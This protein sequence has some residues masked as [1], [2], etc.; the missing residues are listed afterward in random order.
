V[1]QKVNPYGLRLGIINDWRTRWYTEKD[2]AAYL[3][4]DIAIRR[5]IIAQLSHAGLSKIDI[6]RTEKQVKI[7]IHAGRPGIVI[8][9]KGAEVDKL[10]NHL[11]KLTGKRIKIDI[12]EVR[13]PETSAPLIAQNIAQQLEG[14][15]SFRRAMKKAV[16]QAIQGGAK[17]V[18]I[19]SAGRLGG[20][21]MSRTEW[22]REG[23]VPLHTLKADIEYG[24]AEANTKSGKIGVK[25]WVYHGDVPLKGRSIRHV[26]QEDLTEANARPSMPERKFTARKK[27]QAPSASA[28]VSVSEQMAADKRLADAAKAATTVES[29]PAEKP[30]EATAP[31]AKAAAKKPAAKKP[32]VKKSPAAK[33]E[34]KPASKTV[35]DEVASSPKTKAPRNDGTSHPKAAVKKAPAKKPAAKKKEEK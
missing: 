8:G 10:R 21:E 15:V 18:R 24:T 14:R 7:A 11:D 3:K 2:F 22:Y 19:S 13:H 33:A 17:G 6:E 9:K 23:R 27:E 25:V 4:E 30:A 20:A 16:S 29:K 32:A 1:G 12:E 31:E 34:A 5:H 35:K 28:P 26:H